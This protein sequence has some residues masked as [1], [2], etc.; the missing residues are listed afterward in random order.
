MTFD[1]FV[2]H[3]SVRP[4]LEGSNWPSFSEDI[5][6][7]QRCNKMRSLQHYMESWQ[8]ASLILFCMIIS[9][10]SATAVHAQNG[11]RVD[12]QSDS[13]DA[14][15]D[16]MLATPNTST[17]TPLSNLY[18][19]APDLERQI[20][21][22]QVRGNVL[23]PFAW[24]SNA[25]EISHG[26][27]SSGEANPFAAVSWA[28]PIGT[29]PLRATLSG[30][31]ESDRYFR[32]PELN[33]DKTG[34]SA[35]LQ[36]VDPS[37][38]QAFSPF[39][40]FAPRWDFSPTFDS[41]LSARQD[42]NFGFNKRF[43]FDGN[44]RQITFAPDTS[45]STVWSLGLTAFVQRRLREP[46]V[47]SD[48]VFLIP[49]ASYVISSNWNM[50]F[51]VEFIGRWFDQNNLGIATRDYDIHP[52]VTLEYVIPAQF[53]GGEKNARLLGRPALDLQASYLRVWSNAAGGNL[54]QWKAVAALKLGW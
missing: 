30:F 45:A 14:L 26:G 3:F 36:Y 11:A 10:T 54:E 5:H 33:F 2:P 35:R 18:A 20:A 16:A 34:L 8:R 23:L 12:V 40:T 25:E 28:A 9:L 4:V 24:N 38:D 49:S 51:A 37:N 42:F 46:Q 53:L 21:V 29:L 41:Q 6:Q 19:T 13:E 52:I 48:A 47:S 7:A 31:A 22:P 43:N 27:T 50:N 1:L 32:S 44:L 15:R 17:P 39:F